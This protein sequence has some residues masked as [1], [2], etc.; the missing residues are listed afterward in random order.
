[1]KKAVAQVS[2]CFVLWQIDSVVEPPLTK[3]VSDLGKGECGMP[4][5]ELP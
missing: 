1:M 5:S 2:L 4:V 3:I